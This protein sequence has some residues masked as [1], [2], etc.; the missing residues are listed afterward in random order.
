M[1]AFNQLLFS[2]KAQN[3]R[4]TF[5][6]DSTKCGTIWIELLQDLNE[7]SFQTRYLKKFLSDDELLILQASGYVAYKQILSY[8][9]FLFFFSF[10]FIE[11]VSS[12]RKQPR[13]IDLQHTTPFL[14]VTLHFKHILAKILLRIS[15]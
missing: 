12:I 5:P 9:T 10:F 14:E 3:G 11:H 1:V 6:T 8:L 15:A 7:D 4:H 2:E 13:L